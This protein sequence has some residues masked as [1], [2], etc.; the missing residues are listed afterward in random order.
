MEKEEEEVG[1]S[2]FR[3][4]L[5]STEDGEKNMRIIPIGGGLKVE[6]TTPEGIFFFISN[7]SRDVTAVRRMLLLS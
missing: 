2:R 4:I 7:T 5:G 6:I 1:P 3:K